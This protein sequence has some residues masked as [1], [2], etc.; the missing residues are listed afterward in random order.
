[1]SGR[2]SKR[3]LTI[4]AV[5][6]TL[7]V[8]LA[9]LVL[10]GDRDAE[11]AS[12]EESRAIQTAD[13][14]RSSE[15]SAAAGDSAAGDA[16][17][18]SSLVATTDTGELVPP[19]KSSSKSTGAPTST[20]PAQPNDVVSPEAEQQYLHKT[21]EVVETNSEDLT[22]VLDAVTVALS[23]RDDATLKK[24]I[25]ADEPG[26]SDYATDLA[27]RYPP[28]LAAEA[29]PHVDVYSAG[30]TT[31]YFAYQLVTW[32]DAGIESTHTIAV[33]F[34]FV[35]GEWQLTTLGETASDLRFV[36]TVAL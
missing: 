26:A 32:R 17:T 12:S 30:G 8:I 7:A 14:D 21:R 34:R 5:V 18:T 35:N 16:A 22:S 33:M 25:V 28:L 13:D 36:Q 11:Q 24:L 10:T 23:S 9:V 19:R 31:V 4:G 1:M 15:S 27:A 20:T 29:L 2:V 3:G 6:V